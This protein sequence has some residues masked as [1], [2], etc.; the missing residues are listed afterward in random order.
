MNRSSISSAE[1]KAEL[2]G[3]QATRRQIMSNRP[4]IPTRRSGATTRRLFLKQSAV[5]LGPLLIHWRL[6]T[7]A[8][9]PLKPLRFALCADVHK[10]LVHDADSRLE[11]F[12]AAANAHHAEFILQLGDFCQPRDKNRDFLRVWNEFPGRR[13][14]TVGNHDRDGGFAW[15]QVLDFWGMERPYYSFDLNGWH[16]VVTDGNEKNPGQAAPGY[17]RYIGASQLAWIEQDLKQTSSPTLLFSHQSLEDPGGVENGREVRAALEK[18]NHA[19]GWRKVA[20]C[21]SG[22]HHIDFH[23]EINGIHYVQINSMSYSWLGEEYA[24]VRYSSEVDKAYPWLKYTA[25]YKEP[26]FAL[27]SLEPSGHISIQG[28][29]SEFVG[30]SPWE[31]GMPEEK[32]TSRD[33]TRLVPAI[34]DRKLTLRIRSPQ[35]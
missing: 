8:A 29:R 27:L 30:P 13:Y 31:L 3:L 15:Q 17:P 12:V 4:I 35:I 22:H 19:A 33:K 32:G 11:S 34:S 1:R 24:H 6:A 7:A 25:P 20:A 5:A 9:A 10:D 14:H 16:F 18:A 21:F 28:K 2:H 26:L 23:C